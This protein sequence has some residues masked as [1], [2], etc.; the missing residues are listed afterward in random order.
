MR[1]HVPVRAAAVK[2]AVLVSVAV[3]VFLFQVFLCGGY[4]SRTAAAAIG[5]KEPG[6]GEE[7]AGGSKGLGDGQE[8]A[9]SSKAIRECKE[10]T[11][12]S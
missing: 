6:D 12:R 10:Q 2:G 3:L 9:G 8:Q 7:R 5:S 1:V 11:S 4:G